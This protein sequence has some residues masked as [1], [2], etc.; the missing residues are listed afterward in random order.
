MAD[1]I[2]LTCEYLKEQD[3][4]WGIYSAHVGIFKGH[5][6]QCKGFYLFVFGTNRAH[7]AT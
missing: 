6:N 5:V 2:W 4:V 1:Y 7:M 3:S